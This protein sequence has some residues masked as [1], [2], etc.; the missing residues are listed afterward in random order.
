MNLRSAL[1]Y[2]PGHPGTRAVLSFQP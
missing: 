2:A 1:C